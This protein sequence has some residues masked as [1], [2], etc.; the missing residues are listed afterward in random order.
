MF[1]SNGGKTS[2]YIA[3]RV[4]GDHVPHFRSGTAVAESASGAKTD[5]AKL[6]SLGV[7]FRTH[8]AGMILPGLIPAC[9]RLCT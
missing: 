6:H 7:A 4:E 2:Y 9:G 1:S 3:Y 5:R 8:S